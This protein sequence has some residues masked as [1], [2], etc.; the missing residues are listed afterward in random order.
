MG[1]HRA[2]LSSQGLRAGCP[3]GLRKGAVEYT[4]GGWED[5]DYRTGDRMPTVGCAGWDTGLQVK[6]NHF[7]INTVQTIMIL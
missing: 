1:A 3:G 2:D 5:A 6:N 4:G 7:V